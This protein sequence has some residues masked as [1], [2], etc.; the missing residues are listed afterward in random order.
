VDKLKWF[1]IQEIFIECNNNPQLIPNNTPKPE[2]K[3]ERL[4]P[5]FDRELRALDWSSGAWKDLVDGKYPFPN[6]LDR[7]ALWKEGKW[8]SEDGK[9]TF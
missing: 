5:F 3:H 4:R 9:T 2:W 8:V 7:W 1:P 6:A